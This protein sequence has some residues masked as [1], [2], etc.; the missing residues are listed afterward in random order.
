MT[1]QWSEW[2]AC[3]KNRSRTEISCLASS[4]TPHSCPLEVEKEECTSTSPG[5]SFERHFLKIIFEYFS[6]PSRL[7]GMGLLVAVYI[8]LRAR[9]EDQ[10][11]C[12][13]W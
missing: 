12:M 11:S 13:Q 9:G 6:Q 1:P 2:G 10:G 7:A 4:Q 8:K 3:T 5:N